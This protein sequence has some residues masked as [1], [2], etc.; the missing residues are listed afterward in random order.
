MNTIEQA[1]QL[2]RLVCEEYKIS[3]H[4]LRKTKNVAKSKQI[5]KYKKLISLSSIRQSL[6]YFISMY[7]PI[8]KQEIAMIVGY[9]DHTPISSQRNQIEHYIITKD[10]YFYPYYQIV[11]KQADKMGIDRSEKKRFSQYKNKTKIINNLKIYENAK[12][13]C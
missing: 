4:N 8:Q 5:K 10:S 1:Y 6:S 12:T 7:F 9:A 2:V 11:E 13:I 3:P